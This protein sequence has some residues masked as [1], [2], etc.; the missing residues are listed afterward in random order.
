MKH[1]LILLSLSIV[2]LSDDL[3]WVNEQIEAIKPPRKGL[4]ASYIKS[5]KDPFV[6][7]HKV[8]TKDKKRYKK[9]T[10]TRY[11]SNKK[12]TT[13]KIKRVIKKPESNYEL[14]MI[15]NKKFL[16]NNRWYKEGDKINGYKIKKLSFNTVLLDNHK[17]EIILTTKSSNSKLKLINR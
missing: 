15:I 7:L 1:I 9:V 10:K 17:R 2:L 8:D 3:S 6:F 5:I 13:E 4:K 12:K 14:S 11:T 16:I